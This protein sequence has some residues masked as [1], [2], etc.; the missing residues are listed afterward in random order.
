MKFNL[1]RSLF[2]ETDWL[3]FW[4]EIL[5]IVDHSY[6]IKRAQAFR[7][8][9]NLHFAQIIKLSLNTLNAFTFC[10]VNQILEAQ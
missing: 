1:Y 10:S 4:C 9:I 8:T 2:P 6:K 3:F 5:I 7:L